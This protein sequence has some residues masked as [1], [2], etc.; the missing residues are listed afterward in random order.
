MR[1]D[2]KAG[3]PRQERGGVEASE[4]RFRTEAGEQALCIHGLDTGSTNYGLG[5]GVGQEA[6]LYDRQEW[7][8]RAL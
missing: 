4:P 3:E 7:Q 1:R 8:V 5:G 2:V 6:V